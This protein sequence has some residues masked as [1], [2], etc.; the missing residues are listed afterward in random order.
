MRFAESVF[1]VYAWRKHSALESDEYG[2]E[3]VRLLPSSSQCPKQSLVLD[4]GV[5]EC[6]DMACT[7]TPPSAAACSGQ[8]SGIA[9]T[10][11]WNAD[12][13]SSYVY[14]QVTVTDDFYPST[15]TSTSSSMT[16]AGVSSTSASTAMTTIGTTTVSATGPTGINLGILNSYSGGS[17]SGGTSTSTSTGKQSADGGL[18]GATGLSKSKAAAPMVTGMLG[19]MGMGLMAVAA[20]VGG[21]VGF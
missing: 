21:A 4:L 15:S 20:V 7:I 2:A 9:F 12:F 17:G 8:V 16:S 18:G 19:E 1:G 5:D 3:L 13:L 6:S 11:G 14:R 10:T